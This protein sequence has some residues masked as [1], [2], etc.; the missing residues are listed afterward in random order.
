MGKTSQS[1]QLRSMKTE[2]EVNF[3][4]SIRTPYNRFC[5]NKERILVVNAIDAYYMDGNNVSINPQHV[6]VYVNEYL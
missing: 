2:A 6:A 1:E 4:H 5:S 3:V